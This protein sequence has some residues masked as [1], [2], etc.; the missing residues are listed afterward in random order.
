VL[1]ADW[2][3]PDGPKQ[4][5]IKVTDAYV[6]KSMHVKFSRDW[7]PLEVVSDEAAVGIDAGQSF[8]APYSDA[9]L[10]MPSLRQLKPGVTIVR[11]GQVM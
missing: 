5:L 6:A 3:L 11:F 2:C 9:I 1:L 4:R 10:I 7:Q 8:F